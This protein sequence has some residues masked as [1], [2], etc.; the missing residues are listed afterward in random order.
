MNGEPQAKSLPMND[1]FFQ[2][3]I[4]RPVL[5]LLRQ[6]TTPEK[7]ALSIAFGLVLGV[8][9][10]LG[11]TTLL[12]FLAAFMFGLNL[13]AVQLVNYFVYPLQLA[14]LI[15]FIRAGE[16]LFHSPRLPLSLTQILAMIKA[17]VWH[18]IKVL[19]V[20]TAQAIA[21]WVLIAPL[22]IYVLYLVLTPLLRRLALVSGL[23]Q[24]SHGR[25]VC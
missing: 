6:G 18:S 2:R 11:W 9:P 15:P 25:E 17:G 21:V 10:S 14:L 5:D 7:I 4:V 13:P 20:A 12:C 19:W 16:R 1:G 22:S 8:F 23:Q 3:R 24:T